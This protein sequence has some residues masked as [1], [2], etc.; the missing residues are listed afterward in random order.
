MPLLLKRE[1]SHLMLYHVVAEIRPIRLQEG[2][3]A[4]I[5]CS[6]V[7]QLESRAQNFAH[8]SFTHPNPKTRATGVIG[9]WDSTAPLPARAPPSLCS[10][11]CQSQLASKLDLGCHGTALASLRRKSGA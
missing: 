2:A 6:E 1:E 7:A 11:S 9:E 3:K 4:G 8:R 10:Q 5:G